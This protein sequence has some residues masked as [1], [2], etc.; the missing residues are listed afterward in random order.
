MFYTVLSLK[1]LITFQGGDDFI[2][3]YIMLEIRYQVLFSLKY[4]RISFG[5]SSSTNVFNEIRINYMYM[6][7]QI[8]INHYW[9]P[10]EKIA[11]P[12]FFYLFI[13]FFLSGIFVLSE[14]CP[15]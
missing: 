11:D 3:L 7:L 15:L 2:F 12:Y 4:N 8:E 10:H 13:Y 6:Y 14:L 1:T 5:M 9:V